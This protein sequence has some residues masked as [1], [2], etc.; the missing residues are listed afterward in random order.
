LRRV[1]HPWSS[2]SWGCGAHPRWHDARGPW[3]RGAHMQRRCTTKEQ[4]T[5]LCRRVSPALAEVAVGA[6][7]KE[8]RQRRRIRRPEGEV[9]RAGQP[10]VASRLQRRVRVR[11]IH[12]RGEERGG[13]GR[14]GQSSVGA[15]ERSARKKK[16]RGSRGHFPRMRGLDPAW[17][18][19]LAWHMCKSGK[20]VSLSQHRWC[21]YICH[22]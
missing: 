14:G 10:H 19:Q 9:Q 3:G 13:R 1:Q 7:A 15:A 8:T 22:R 2:S 5:E 4:V 17:T 16:G 12:K 18:A 6:A 21:K 11:R 20:C